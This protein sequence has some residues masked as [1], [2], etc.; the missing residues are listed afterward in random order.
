[1]PPSSCVADVESFVDVAK[2]LDW[3][4]ILIDRCNRVAV[5]VVEAVVGVGEKVASGA[6]YSVKKVS[7]MKKRENHLIFEQKKIGRPQ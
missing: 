5:R 7:N 6:W 4:R 1:M 3:D 2:N